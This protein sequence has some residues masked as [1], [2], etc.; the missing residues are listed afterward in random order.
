[1]PSDRFQRAQRA[2]APADVILTA[3]VFDHPDVTPPVRLVDAMSDR[4]I[5]GA[6]YTAARLDAEHGSATLD[7]VPAGR[8][9][10]DNVGQVLATWMERT[11]GG[12]HGT[13]RIIRC[14][15]VADP[16]I[17]EDVTYEIDGASV[18]TGRLEVT[19][20]FRALL[21]RPAVRLRYDPENSP[22]VFLQ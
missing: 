13:V 21:D 12:L 10:V 20:G 19:L 17:E 7:Q 16:A 4:A 6:A 22:G 9:S 2:T 14:L 5:A 8:I 1:M 15:D 3:V 18:D 11:S